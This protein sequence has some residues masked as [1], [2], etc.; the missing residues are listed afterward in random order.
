MRTGFILIQSPQPERTNMASPMITRSHGCVLNSRSANKA[1]FAVVRLVRGRCNQLL[2]SRFTLPLY[3]ISSRV[4]TGGAWSIRAF[5]G[6]LPTTSIGCGWR[7]VVALVAATASSSSATSTA[8]VSGFATF[9]VSFVSAV[10]CAIWVVRSSSASA[11]SSSTA[12]FAASGIVLWPRRLIVVGHM[13]DVG[14]WRCR[15]SEYSINMLTVFSVSEGM[16]KM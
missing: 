8:G 12:A 11:S 9:N 4:V 7:W 3:G 1:Y 6:W 15:R 5:T 2:A 13:C 10:I 14:R 16:C